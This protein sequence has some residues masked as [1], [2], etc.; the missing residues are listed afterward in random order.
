MI[1]CGN[2]RGIKAIKPTDNAV[3]GHH[4]GNST[5]NEFVAQIFKTI[6]RGNEDLTI[7]AIL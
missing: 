2:R 4:K 7:S 6:I 3:G 5:L 1:T